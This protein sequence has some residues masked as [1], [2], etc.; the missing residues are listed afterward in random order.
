MAKAKTTSPPPQQA[1]QQRA[2]S[3]S[4]EEIAAQIF[5][6]TYMDTAGKTVEHLA[7]RSFE[8]AEAF[9]AVAN[10]RK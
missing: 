8:A 9:V 10:S 3:V 1:G 6:K 4:V 7:S 2:A 5:I